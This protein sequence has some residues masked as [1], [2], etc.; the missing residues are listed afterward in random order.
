MLYSLN[1]SMTL[2]ACP[3]LCC[4]NVDRL[5]CFVF[6]ASIFITSHLTSPHLTSPHLTS[7]HLTSP[8]LTSPHL[9][10]PHLTITP[11]HRGVVLRSLVHSLPHVLATNPLSSGMSALQPLSIPL[12]VYQPTYF[13]VVD[14]SIQ[15]LN[16]SPPPPTGRA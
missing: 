16:P 3:M 8:H 1:E 6:F 9:T 5:L 12:Y 11:A 10:S 2:T 7:P 13:R 15:L 4:L 14:S